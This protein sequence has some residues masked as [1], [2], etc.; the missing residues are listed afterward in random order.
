[1]IRIDA[2]GRIDR[3]ID[4]PVLKPTCC[5]FGGPDLD[6]LYIT[7]SRMGCTEEQLSE[8]PLAGALFAVRPGVGGIED[9]PFAG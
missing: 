7:S 1:V 3:I 5:A 9:A 2:R 6:T 8:Q 4:V